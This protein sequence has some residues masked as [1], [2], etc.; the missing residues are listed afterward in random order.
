MANRCSALS[1]HD[2]ATRNHYNSVFDEMDIGWHWDAETYGSLL[3]QGGDR[4]PVR[5]YVERHRPHLLR[6]YA[7]DNLVNAIESMRRDRMRVLAR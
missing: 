5:T 1:A 4:E 3:A 2:E 7:M 6:A